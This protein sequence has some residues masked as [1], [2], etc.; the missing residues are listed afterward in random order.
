MILQ[1]QQK[2]NRKKQKRFI[3]VPGDSLNYLYALLPNKTETEV[4][5]LSA[6]QP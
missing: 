3:V 2:R 1:N 4:L 5:R 6:V